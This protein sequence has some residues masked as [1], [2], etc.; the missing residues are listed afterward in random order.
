MPKLIVVGL[1]LF[2]K[3]SIFDGAGYPN[4]A[5]LFYYHCFFDDSLF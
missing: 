2:V 5:D 4:K 3:K 1:L